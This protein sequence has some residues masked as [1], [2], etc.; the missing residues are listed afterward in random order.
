MAQVSDSAAGDGPASEIRQFTV[1]RARFEPKRRDDLTAD[2]HLMI[3]V[4]GEFTAQRLHDGGDYDG[5]WE[6][7]TPQD[8]RFPWVYL[9]D[10]AD[11]EIVKP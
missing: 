8:W 7:D 4:E 1:I 11:V 9:C 6:L 3:G 10:L 2:G 5:E